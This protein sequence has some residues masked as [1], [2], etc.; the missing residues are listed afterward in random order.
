MPSARP[1]NGFF[2]ASAADREAAGGSLPLREAA[3]RACRTL[4]QGTEAC[5]D[6]QQSIVLAAQA[7]SVITPIWIRRNGEVRYLTTQEINARL[8]EGGRAGRLPEMKGLMV[9]ESDLHRG[10]ESLRAARA[11][12]GPSNLDHH[13]DEPPA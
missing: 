11:S 6:F 3:E 1:L 2:E 8:F 10:I 12:F 5:P 4:G 13:H 7:L 9:R